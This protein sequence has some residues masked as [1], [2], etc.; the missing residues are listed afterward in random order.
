MSELT[1]ALSVIGAALDADSLGDLQ[2]RLPADLRPAV[3]THDRGATPSEEE[4]K[5]AIAVVVAADPKA[6]HLIQLHM[7]P[8]EDL[9]LLKDAEIQTLMMHVDNPTLVQALLG[10]DEV[11]SARLLQNLSARRRA[12]VQDDLERAEQ[13]LE[14]A[15]QEEVVMAQRSILDEV[16][17]QYDAGRID[18]YFGSAERKVRG[19]TTTEDAKGV[20]P[21]KKRKPKATRRGGMKLIWL[22]AVIAV[23]GVLWLVVGMMGS[24]SEQASKEVP[25]VKAKR[26]GGIVSKK[27]ADAQPS[28]TSRRGKQRRSQ[29][30]AP[31]DSL[32]T[33]SAAAVVRLP[34]AT[35]RTDVETE[36]HQRDD[37]EGNPGPLY[38]RLGSVR[39]EVLRDDFI[40]QTPVV[41]ISG[42]VGSRF[43][44][45][46][47][48]DATTRVNVERGTVLVRS[49][50][51][52]NRHWVISEGKQGQFDS[53]GRVQIGNNEARRK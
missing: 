7:F 53:S 19:P 49:L 27:K 15:E 11:L 34:G 3:G 10:A 41:E 48:L 38:L 35:V 6:A 25:A 16:R 36:I 14:R 20:K 32:K 51:E 23:A 44:T 9:D 24:S 4:L 50:L 46:V 33:D 17:R 30:L 2:S 52:S 13:E 22:A 45:R 1:D 29:T 8:F 26:S 43:A 31:G 42:S 12:I 40:L 21:K 37:R 39:V 18:T 28:R 5:R 47:V